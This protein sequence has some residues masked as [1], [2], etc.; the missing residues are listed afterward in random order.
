[1]IF[2]PTEKVKKD[3][4]VPWKRDRPLG[5]KDTNPWKLRERTEDSTNLASP[6]KNGSTEHNQSPTESNQ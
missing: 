5:S 1:M 4:V 3:N 2:V 6:S